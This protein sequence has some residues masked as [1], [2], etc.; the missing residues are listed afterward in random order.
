[1]GKENEPKLTRR[2]FLKGA[3]LTLGS[4]GVGVILGSCS[5]D[6]KTKGFQ[7]GMETL[8][9]ENLTQAP[10]VAQEKA[11]HFTP[12]TTKEI[13]Q[14]AEATKEEKT[15]EATPISETG[16]LEER[17]E[18][19]KR[20]TPV[21][22]ESLTSLPTEESPQEAPTPKE[23]PEKTRYEIGG[24]DFADMETPLGMTYLTDFEGKRTKVINNLQIL[25]SETPSTKD[26]NYLIF[27]RPTRYGKGKLLVYPEVPSE[28]F[29]LGAHVGYI[30]NTN[31]AMELEPFRR[32]IEGPIT[33]RWGRI[34]A[35]YEEKTVLANLEKT[36]GT[37]FVFR[38][39]DQEAKFEIIKAVR[40]NAEKAKEYN[41]KGNKISEVFD[42]FET[43][44]NSFIFLVCS[45]GQPN[46]APEAQNELFPG[47]FVF[48][49]QYSP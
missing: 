20:S 22:K 25:V 12:T 28:T 7:K 13:R 18:I 46:D 3:G 40:M 11:A 1:M 47:R 37:E 15:P 35:P 6:K 45:R 27:I 49:L 29:V 32:M 14:I 43:P 19:D 9:P 36:I 4:A 8:F 31:I 17:K 42:S 41:L 21:Q 5:P 24:I 10:K 16:P 34:I 26:E 23:T 2:D 33:D 44:D 48:V 30:K 39:G 38:Q